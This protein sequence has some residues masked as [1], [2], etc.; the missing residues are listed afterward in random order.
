MEEIQTEET[1][2]MASIIKAK[3]QDRLNTYCA[4]EGPRKSFVIDKAIDL[5]LESKNY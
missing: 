4:N 2:K 3:T 5:Y 1:V